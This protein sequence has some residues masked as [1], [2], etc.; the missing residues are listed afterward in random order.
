MV[1]AL[2]QQADMPDLQQLSFDDRFGLIVDT[3]HTEQENAKFDRRLNKANLRQ[4]SSVEDIDFHSGRGLDRTTFSQLI[5]CKWISDKLNIL[6]TGKTGVGKSYIACA[7][8]KK[9]C[10]LGFTAAYFRSSR[11]FEELAVSKLNAR[12]RI[13]LLNRLA[14]VN[15]LII[16]DFALAPMTEEQSRDLLEIM[17]DRYDKCSSI[18]VSQLPVKNWYDVIPNATI[19]DAILDR[20]IHGAYRIE[21]EGDTYRDK[22]KKKILTPVN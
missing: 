3:E 5:S 11:M 14:K 8:A 18:I 1:K 12:G 10:R 15:L 4:Q 17:D 2:E 22:K 16:D 6:I 21:L 9:A 20:V 19:A 13:N 7:L